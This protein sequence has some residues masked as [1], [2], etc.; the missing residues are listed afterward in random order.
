MG[1]RVVGR[2]AQVAPSCNIWNAQ[3]ARI[4][5]TISPVLYFV[6]DKPCF[7]EIRSGKAKEI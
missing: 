5:R 3:E 6:V 1:L 2:Y 4:N 7:N